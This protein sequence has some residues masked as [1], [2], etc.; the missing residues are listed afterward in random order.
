M[1]CSVLQSNLRTRAYGLR[2]F[3]AVTVV[4]WVSL[5]SFDVGAKTELRADHFVN[6]VLERH[7]GPQALAQALK[8][9]QARIGPAGALPDPMLGWAIA[10]D[11]VGDEQIGTRQIWQLNQ[12]IP[13]PG[14]LG[15]KRAAAAAASDAQAED[16]AALRLQITEKARRAYGQWYFVHQA[17]HI[18]ADNQALLRDL[19]A[20]ANQLYA[21]GRGTQQAVLQAGL[22]EASLKREALELG[23]Q[24]LT[25]AA[26]INALRDRP[27]QTPVGEP[28]LWP[29]PPAL[30]TVDV[31]VDAAWKLQPGLLALGA[32]EQMYERRVR[33]AKREYFP[34]LRLNLS[35]LGTL[36]PPEKRLQ[37][38][39][40]LN[41]P[42]NFSRRRQEVDAAQAEVLRSQWAQRDLAAQ[43]AA[44]VASAYAQAVQSR[45]TLL[46]YRRELL[47]LAEQNLVAAQADWRSGAG[48][49][50][51][52]VDAEQQLL[53]TRLGA[54]RARVDEWVARA[55]LDR[56]VADPNLNLFEETRP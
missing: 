25:I 27:V 20:V 44:A 22:R 12:A 45:Q 32:R 26:T 50:Q 49:F 16:L 53:N 6:E 7:P 23:Q 18:N 48:D 10:P 5:I 9:A 35:Q 43:I 47:P 56:Q 54:E 38:G 31:L 40:S 36:D 33:L 46:L 8:A 30:P 29:E 52:V 14:K 34:D 39:I 21:S 11:T 42:L 37:A 4:A 15:L 2:R 1:T 41:V 17:L 28:V 51:A 3:T 55:A 24:Q 13:W 19:E